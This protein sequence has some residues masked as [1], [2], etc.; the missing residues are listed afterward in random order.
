M[1]S[2]IEILLRP[3]K[4]EP[5]QKG[6]RIVTDDEEERVLFVPVDSPENPDSRAIGLALMVGHTLY[7]TARTMINAGEDPGQDGHAIVTYMEVVLNPAKDSEE[8]TNDN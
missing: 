5:P 1:P 3:W 2:M 8:E 7:R 6:G 4:L